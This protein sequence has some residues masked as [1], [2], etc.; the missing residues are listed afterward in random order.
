MRTTS[1]ACDNASGGRAGDGSCSIERMKKHLLAVVLL[2]ACAADLP[3]ADDAP[4]PSKI[5]VTGQA[6]EVSAT[7]GISPLAG[8][9]IE[10]YVSSDDVTPIAEATTDVLGNYSLDI[11]TDSAT[12][13]DGY[14]RATA[15][16][17]VDTYVYAPAALSGNYDGAPVRM[18]KSDTLA[19]LEYV[20]GAEQLAG[21]GMIAAIVGNDQHTPIAGATVESMPAAN[22][23]CYSGSDGL[24]D[25]VR[26]T[27]NSD[28][29]AYAFNVTGPVTVSAT[30]T[31]ATFKQRKVTSR[32]DVVTLVLL[33]P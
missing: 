31:S 8:L 2:T 32:A 26:L 30:K 4:V 6:A 27:T 18:V 22:K 5:R 33:A 9:T 7:S 15:A 24:P 12:P 3:S 19:A 28:G 10:A 14:L 13:F 16:G 23:Y 29:V 21:N 17:Y 11:T 25:S 20:C 1:A